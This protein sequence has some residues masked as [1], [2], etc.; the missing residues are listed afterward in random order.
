MLQLPSPFV[1][2]VLQSNPSPWVGM[3]CH[4][5]T[6]EAASQRHLEDSDKKGLSTVVDDE[7][8]PGVALAWVH[9]HPFPLRCRVDPKIINLEKKQN[10]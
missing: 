7:R 1:R 8:P 3:K 5:F 9:D 2:F 6:A 10:I 4:I